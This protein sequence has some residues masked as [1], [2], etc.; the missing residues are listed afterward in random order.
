MPRDILV[1]VQVFNPRKIGN[2]IAADVTHRLREMIVTCRLK[3]N[4]ALRFEPLREN[5]GARTEPSPK[6]GVF[7][8]LTSVRL[9]YGNA[10]WNVH[11]CAGAPLAS[12]FL[13]KTR[14]TAAKTSRLPRIANVSL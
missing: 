11:Q 14:T 4:E 1:N 12:P 3:P 6:E 5:F 2:T 10:F 7:T 8:T 9:K 13:A